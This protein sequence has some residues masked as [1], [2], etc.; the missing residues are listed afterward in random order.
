MRKRSPSWSARTPS[1]CTWHCDA[2]GSTQARPRRWR[3]RYSCEPGTAWAGSRS[4]PASRPGCTGSP[5]TKLIDGSRA[6][7][8]HRSRPAPRRR[9]RW[10]GSPRQTIWARRHERSITSS[11][12]SSNTRWRSFRPSGARL[13]SSATSSGCPRRRPLRWSVSARAR[14]RAASTAGA[15]SCAPSSSPIWGSRRDRWASARPAV[16]S[17]RRAV[18]LERSLKRR[19]RLSAQGSRGRLA[20]AVQDDEG[21]R[22]RAGALSQ[23]GLLVDVDLADLEGPWTLGGDLIDHW[24]DQAA[25]PAPRRPIVDE[26]WDLRPQHLFLEVLLGERDRVGHMDYLVPVRIVRAH[27]ARPCFSK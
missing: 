26:H 15:C 16:Q 25:G 4:G 9:I 7:R 22:A 27:A 21:D 13:L 24:V 20:V 12:R 17:C 18:E 11:R 6:G 8:R 23:L 19:L 2:S 3:K 14:S 10:R 1:G 5:S